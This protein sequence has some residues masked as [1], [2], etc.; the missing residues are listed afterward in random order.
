MFLSLVPRFETTDER[1]TFLI[2]IPIHDA[3][4]GGNCG[5]DCDSDCD[6][7]LTERQRNIL[8]LLQE[9]GTRIAKVIATLTNLSKRTVDEELSYLRKNGFIKKETNDNR[10]PWVVLRRLDNTENN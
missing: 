2:H 8:I 5:S 10:S 3:F 4:T 6:I 7:Q 9:D 1:L